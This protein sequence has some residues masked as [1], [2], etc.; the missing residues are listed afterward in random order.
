MKPDE[1]GPIHQT[2]VSTI[3]SSDNTR[4]LVIEQ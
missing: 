1:N 2:L 4:R 3:P